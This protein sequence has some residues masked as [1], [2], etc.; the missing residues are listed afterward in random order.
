MHLRRPLVAA[1]AVAALGAGA[2]APALAHTEAERTS[3][4]A[5]AKVKRANVHQVTVTF[6]EAIRTGSIRVTGPGGAV[7]SKG[8]GGR[9]PRNIRRIRVH[10]KSNLAKGR[11]TA[12]WSAK[13]ADGHEQSGSFGFRLR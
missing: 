1:L 7:A 12:R 11:Y 3:P 13:A 10:L 2:A 4:K 5:G 8:A 9:D 6:G